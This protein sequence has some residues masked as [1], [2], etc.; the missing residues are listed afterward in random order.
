MP[1]ITMCKGEA[2]IKK[3]TCFRYKAEPNAFRQSYFKR[4]PFILNEDK[5]EYICIHYWKIA[6]RLK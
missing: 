6:E 3:D 5:G 1:D 2:C 4:S